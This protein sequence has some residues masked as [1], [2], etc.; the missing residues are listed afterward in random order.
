MNG[1]WAAALVGVIGAT[2]GWCAAF[3]IG[4][5]GLSRLLQFAAGVMVG[6]SAF[7]LLPEAYGAGNLWLALGGTA[8]GELFCG[9]LQH[10][11]PERNGGELSAAA[12]CAA[13]GIAAHNLPEGL[14]IGAGY[15]AS[16]ALGGRLALTI[17]LHDV[18]EGA[19]V[20]LPL[21]L[22]G[23][24][25]LYALAVTVASGLPTALGAL[26]ALA[27]GAAPPPTVICLSL[28]FAAGAM[29]WVSLAALIPAAGKDDT[30]GTVS[31][32][33]GILAGFA[34]SVI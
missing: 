18:P 15:A 8:L 23:K 2:L 3:L 1:V 29:L 4:E 24:S 19:G 6:V 26:A 9:A 13:A 16:A 17:L 32:I 11:F 20:A 21:R 27:F 33:L 10:F 12:F 30:A 31:L 25:P 7:E 28:S 22:T 5:R 14:A 34:A